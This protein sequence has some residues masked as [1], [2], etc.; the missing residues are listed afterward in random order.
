MVRNFSGP[1][2][3]FLALCN[4]MIYGLSYCICDKLCEGNI[5]ANDL[6]CGKNGKIGYF[7][8]LRRNF[9]FPNFVNIAP[10]TA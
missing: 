5:G 6:K 9:Y 4:R 2:E 7:V 1:V 8:G 3:R 10:A